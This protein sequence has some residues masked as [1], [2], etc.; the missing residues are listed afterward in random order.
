MRKAVWPKA[1]K[2]Q[3]HL[4]DRFDALLDDRTGGE[5][6]GLRSGGSGTATF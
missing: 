2:N 6:I 5:G 3:K 4:K 1:K